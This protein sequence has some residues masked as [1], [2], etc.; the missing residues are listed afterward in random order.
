MIGTGLFSILLVTGSMMHAEGPTRSDAP[1]AVLVAKDSAKASFAEVK[2]QRLYYQMAGEGPNLL[3]LHGGLSSSED[4]QKLIPTLAKHFRV[5][6]VD[7]VGHGRSSDSGEPFVYASMAEDMKAFLDVLGIQATFVLGWSDGGIVGYHLASKYPRLVT[8]LIALGANTRVEGLSPGTLQWLQ[9]RPTPE[10]LLADLPEVA[11]DYRRVSPQPERL[12][13]FIKRSRDLWLRDPYLAPE[14]LKKI[15]APVLL[16][17]GDRNDIRI[18]HLLELR[19]AMP[20]ARLC[21]L[22]NASHFV[23]KEKPNLLLPI[24]LDFLF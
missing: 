21:I 15:E 8:K 16:I 10:S 7:R 6:T 17:A 1:M 20:R 2:G 4:F 5:I 12:V 13:D 22:P 9:A 3:L 23:L 24:V 14:A 19:T 18:E 11:A